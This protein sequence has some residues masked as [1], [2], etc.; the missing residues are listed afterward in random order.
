[1]KKFLMLLICPVFLLLTA[2][3]TFNASNNPNSLILNLEIKHD[4]DSTFKS[5]K[6][7]LT[8]RNKSNSGLLINRRLLAIPLS[9]PPDEA[10][11]LLLISDLKG[12]LIDM[13]DVN[14]NYSFP[15]TETFRLLKPGE[16]VV[17]SYYLSA[18]F[19]P[20]DFKRGETYKIVMIYQNEFDFS[21]SISGL[22][23]SA[24][25]GSIHSNEQTFVILP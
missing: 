13:S 5:F 25:I 9:V 24:W 21:E 18:W 2:C 20:S 6:A 11:I 8:L 22:D 14:I 4:Q 3:K 1:M 16:Q 10:E 19:I 7:Q 17:K 23:V 15:S 12:N